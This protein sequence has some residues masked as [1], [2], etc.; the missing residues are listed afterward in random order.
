MILVR[1]LLSNLRQA[2]PIIKIFLDFLRAC[3]Q[4]SKY[5]AHVHH[6]DGATDQSP[7]PRNMTSTES[8]YRDFVRD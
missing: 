3:W 6:C 5:S 1:N 8:I 4:V 7:K 2:M